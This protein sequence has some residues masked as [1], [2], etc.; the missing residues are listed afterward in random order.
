MLPL[1]HVRDVLLRTRCHRPTAIEIITTGCRAYFVNFGSV[2]ALPVLKALRGLRMPCLRVLQIEPFKIAFASSGATHD[3]V[4]G[5]I[6]PFEY[7]MRL[8]SGSGRTFNDPAQYPIFTWVVADY[9]SAKLDLTSPTSFRD[10]TQPM[11]CQNRERLAQLI[12]KARILAQVGEPYYLFSSGYSCPLS[13]Y[14]WLIRVEPFTSLHVELQ[15]GRFDHA[16]RQFSS[17][18]A[19][20]RLTTTNTNDYRELMP[21]FFVDG[22]F[23]ENREGFD[24]GTVDGQSIANVALPPW[25][26]SPTEFV[27]MNRKALESSI[28]SAGIPGWIDLVWGERSRG[29]KARQ[30]MNCFQPLM[31][32]VYREGMNSRERA[33]AEGTQ[34]NVGQIPPQ[35][36]D[37][38]HP[39]RQVRPRVTRGQARMIVARVKPPIWAGVE[40]DASFVSVTTVASGGNAVNLRIPN[41]KVFAR[42]EP[43]PEPSQKMILAFEECTRPLAGPYMLGQPCEL[44]RVRPSRGAVELVQTRGAPILACAQDGEWLATANDDARVIVT[45]AGLPR[46]EIPTFTSRIVNAGLSVTWHALVLAATEG[47]FLYDLSGDFVKF[48]PSAKRPVSVLITNGWGFILVYAVSTEGRHFLQLHTINGDLIRETELSR[49]VAV[50]SSSTDRDGFDFISLVDDAG[51]LFHFEAFWLDLGA[52]RWTAGEPVLVVERSE[53][54]AMNVIVTS[55]GRVVFVSD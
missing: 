47:L 54:L 27:Y 36:F 34:L 45:E 49:A 52:A 30:A 44:W 29:E 26:G 43:L 4:E 6:S 41:S 3:W 38:P 5:R 55:D 32:D 22:S 15:S 16:N 10:L 42:G 14:L 21:E 53:E 50:W 2:L 1:D 40:F 7:L 19:A 39:M 23:L 37:R 9:E 51:N 17:M 11:G 35:L 46:V 13:V 24:L 48:V 8:N 28:A 31:Y 12:E 33:E 18:A 25:A 20:W